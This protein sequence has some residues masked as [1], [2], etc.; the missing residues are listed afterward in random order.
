MFDTA[1]LTTMPPAAYTYA[2]PAELAKRE[3]LRRYGAHGTS[4][5]YLVGAA[6]KMLGRPAAELNLI[7]G[8][9]GAVAGRIHAVSGRSPGGMSLHLPVLACIAAQCCNSGRQ[10]MAGVIMRMACCVR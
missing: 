8:H 3:G 4:Y 6:A 9:I 5:R 10:Q 7:I 2:L 1:Y